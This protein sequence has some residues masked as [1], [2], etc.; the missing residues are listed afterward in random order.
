MVIHRVK[1]RVKSRQVQG[2]QGVKS[3]QVRGE[4][5]VKFRQG[6]IQPGRFTGTSEDSST[7]QGFQTAQ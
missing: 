7:V 5:G 4:Q 6:K 2:E 3:R 1:G